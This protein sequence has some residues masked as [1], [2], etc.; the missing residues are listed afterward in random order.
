[1]LITLRVLRL[2]HV[3]DIDIEMYQYNADTPS[4]NAIL[5]SKIGFLF[6]FFL[7]F[8]FLGLIQLPKAHSVSA[9]NL[10]SV[11]AGQ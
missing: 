11:V 4:Q 7:S 2:C 9:I 10:F 3:K 5:Q 8:F 1:M 6:L